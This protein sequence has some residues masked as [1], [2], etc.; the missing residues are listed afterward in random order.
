MPT[1]KNKRNLLKGDDLSPIKALG[2]SKSHRDTP[3]NEKPRTFRH[4]KPKKRRDRSRR[5][6]QYGPGPLGK[7]RPPLKAIRISGGRKR[8][9]RNSRRRN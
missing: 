8:T 7:S 9:R 4:R 6:H 5:R 1:R 3:P 2:L